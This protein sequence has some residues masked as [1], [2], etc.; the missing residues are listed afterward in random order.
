[1]YFGSV[2]MHL[3]YNMKYNPATRPVEE[4]FSSTSLMVQHTKFSVEKPNN[5]IKQLE[6]FIT[7]KES[8]DKEAF[9]SFFNQL[10][11][12]IEIQEQVFSRPQILKSLSKIRAA[13][14]ESPFT[15]R[16][17]K[18]P[19]GYQGDFETINYII[20][21]ENQAKEG[22]FAYFEE[23][24]FLHSEI[25]QQHKNK[26][27]YQAQLIREAISSKKD[28]KIISIGCGTS[29]DIKSC[30]E[31]INQSNSEITLVDIDQDAI[32]F[33]L[34]Q[35]V[36]IKERVIPIHG[37]IYK[38]IRSLHEKYDLIL[39][40][41]VFDYLNDKT[42]ISLLS[43]LRNNLCEYGKL[44]FTNIGKNNPY[45]VFMEYL[46]DWILIERSENDLID[47]I[48]AAN[49]PKSTYKITKDKT[50]LTHLVELNYHI[51]TFELNA[52]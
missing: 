32:D 11:L 44:F 13:C 48:N 19:R 40:G 51:E 33:S 38:V 50:G 36:K 35:L 15:K 12:E 16:V 10:K 25:C 22:T 41:G 8:W 24:Y 7:E 9:N 27:A 2:K 47:L 29:E 20:K 46:A 30:I 6:S 49:W 3:V 28:A 1:L 52:G 21:G 18:W 45:R 5:V 43:S 4:H 42:I 17:Q 14:S 37:S 39:I 34:Q 31:V 23:D 26:V